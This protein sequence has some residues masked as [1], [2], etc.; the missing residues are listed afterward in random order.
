MQTK[1]GQRMHKN[2]TDMHIPVLL[3]E[4][5]SVPQILYEFPTRAFGG[6]AEQPPS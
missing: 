1:L 3:V 4:L 2:T 5:M 6:S